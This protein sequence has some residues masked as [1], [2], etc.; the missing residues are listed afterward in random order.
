MAEVEHGC[1]VLADISGY[2][3][4]LG[5]VELEHCHDVVA[6]L[7]GVVGE[8]MRG[9]LRVAK[10]EGDAVFGYDPQD[11]IDAEVLVATIE[12]CYF[13]FARLRRE[14][15]VNRACPCDACRRVAE[16]DL[17]FVAHHGS[18]VE[19]RIGGSP[20]LVGS[21]VVLVHRLLK[22]S[23]GERTGFRGYALLTAAGVERLGIE[24]A[25]LGLTEHTETYEGVG[26]VAG[27]VHDLDLRW[28]EEEERTAVIVAPEESFAT[29]EGEVRVPPAVAWEYMTSPEKKALWRIGVKRVD[30]LNKRG[31]R[32][33]GATTHCVMVPPYGVYV[34]RCLDWKPY[35]YHT[36]SSRGR[37]GEFIY[38]TELAPLADGSGTHITSRFQ[39]VGRRARVVARLVGRRRQVS[40]WQEGVDNL[41][42]LLNE[43]ADSD[44]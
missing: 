14:I 8:Q 10:F 19:E 20:E 16:L 7:L 31:T 18:Y 36:F 37:F 6:K 15:E 4:Y 26:E 41:T 2:T 27:W 23:V 35:R 38:T 40:L 30:T 44:L 29:I 33:V 17:K 13:A 42:A 25:G 1:L 11:R 28:R 5:G 39:L 12:A 32:G 21:D 3:E 24:A 43:L 34:E 9:A 22:S